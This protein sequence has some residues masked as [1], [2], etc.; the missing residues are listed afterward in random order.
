MLLIGIGLL[1]GCGGDAPRK[2]HEI[3]VDSSPPAATKSRGVDGPGPI[4]IEMH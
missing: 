1:S 2:G 4:K 3:P